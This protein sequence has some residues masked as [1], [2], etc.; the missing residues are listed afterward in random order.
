ML[1]VAVGFHVSG[2]GRGQHGAAAAAAGQRSMSA[3]PYGGLRL[4]QLAQLRREYRRWG[5]DWDAYLAKD[6]FDR[7]IADCDSALKLSPGDAMA[8]FTRGNGY[9]FKGQFELALADFE[10]AT[11]RRQLVLP[12]HCLK[13]KCYCTSVAHGLLADPA[14]KLENWPAPLGRS[15]ATHRWTYFACSSCWPSALLIPTMVR[16][17][18]IT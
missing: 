1:V 6:E 17:R 10:A 14:T 13:S 18:V 3:V 16:S 11:A 4:R 12:A 9:L 2:A 8:H 15:A 5:L 7:T